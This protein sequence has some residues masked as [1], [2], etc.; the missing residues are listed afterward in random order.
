MVKKK[1]NHNSYFLKSMLTT[2]NQNSKFLNDYL[3]LLIGISQ[4]TK[5][6]VIKFC[7]LCF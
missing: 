4:K 5:I 2:L 1:I 3:F 7:V 6:S